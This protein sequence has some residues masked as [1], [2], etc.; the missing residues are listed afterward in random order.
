MLGLIYD[1]TLDFGAGW[2]S[3]WQ[4]CNIDPPRSVEIPTRGEAG[5]GIRDG[6]EQA[7]GDGTMRGSKLDDQIFIWE[8][9]MFSYNI[10]EQ[11]PTK[12]YGNF[13]FR[14]TFDN[15]KIRYQ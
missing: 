8:K 4:I 3:M 9:N 15:L 7:S 14:F 5:A 10:Y 1:K 2:L 6:Q 11:Q 12:I 13:S